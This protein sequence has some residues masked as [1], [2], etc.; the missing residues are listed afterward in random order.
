MARPESNE[1]V[2]RAYAAASVAADVDAAA[3]LRHPEWIVEWPQ[4]GERVTSSEAFAEIVR[5]Y[6]GGAPSAKVR[7]I[8]G[9][10][11]RWLVTPSNTVIRVGG[12]GDAWWGEWVVTYP[13]GG[14]YYCIDL[15]ELRDGLVYR[16]T[17][18][19]AAPFAAP[20]WRAPWV[21]R[22]EA[23]ADPA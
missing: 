4:S 7:R 16:E 1:E 20:E 3:R 12:E 2:V 18:Y 13:D 6:P 10:Q 19:W 8:V 15:I 21:E 5:N 14:T 9:D 22:A 17:V 23:A 11:D